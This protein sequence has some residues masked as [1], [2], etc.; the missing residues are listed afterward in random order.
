MYQTIGTQPY[1]GQVG[2]SYLPQQQLGFNQFGVNQLGVNQLGVNQLGLNRLGPNQLGV[3]QLGTS[4]YG[5]LNNQ[6]LGLAQQ[7]ANLGFLQSGLKSTQNEQRLIN[8]K[9]QRNQLKK[10][11]TQVTGDPIQSS[12][13]SNNIQGRGALDDFDLGLGSKNSL[14]KLG[15]GGNSNL[16]SNL[17]ALGNLANLGGNANNNSNL[18]GSL[19]TL[20]SLANLGKTNNNSNLLGNLGTL[21]S[22]ANLGNN[23]YLV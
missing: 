12:L 4:P 14:S 19:G 23:W 16:L 15:L 2:T 20:S 18:L 9:A 22:L 21:S 17:G 5:L 7:Q 1:A 6:N 3:N 11:L 8:E 10:L 13:I